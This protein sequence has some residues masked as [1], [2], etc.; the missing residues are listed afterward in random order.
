MRCRYWSETFPQPAVGLAELLAFLQGVVELVGLVEIW[1]RRN[2]R[3]TSAP[4]DSEFRK[5]HKRLVAAFRQQ[6]EGQVWRQVRRN[7]RR[8]CAPVN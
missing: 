2:C 4:E 1:V 7:C 8:T 3:R 5:K 6:V